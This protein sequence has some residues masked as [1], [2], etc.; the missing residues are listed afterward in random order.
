MIKYLCLAAVAATLWSGA[1]TAQTCVLTIYPPD[2]MSPMARAS[3]VYPWISQCREREEL[4][5]RLMFLDAKRN[6]EVTG[7]ICTTTI[8]QNTITTIC[9]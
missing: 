7:T 5:E 6:G 8:N 9:Q 1:A 4:A 2:D 3:R